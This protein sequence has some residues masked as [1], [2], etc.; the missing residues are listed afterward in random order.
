M[1]RKKRRLYPCLGMRLYTKSSF[2]LF[3]ICLE[4]G[5]ADGDA[6]TSVEHETWLARYLEDDGGIHSRVRVLI[7]YLAQIL[8]RLLYI[9][10]SL[11]SILN[12]RL[13]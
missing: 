4:R 9:V 11:H 7:G 10:Y 5:V 8:Q 6:E 2:T 12:H 3:A 1:R 13:D